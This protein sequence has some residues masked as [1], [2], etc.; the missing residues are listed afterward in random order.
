MASIDVEAERDK[1]RE[2]IKTINSKVVLDYAHTPE[3]LKICL[4]NLRNHY[5]FS[6]ITIV[7]LIIVIISYCYYYYYYHNNHH[8]YH[9]KGTNLQD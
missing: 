6:K 4:E 2:D 5:S 9:Y 1:L 3:A 8:Y 7:F